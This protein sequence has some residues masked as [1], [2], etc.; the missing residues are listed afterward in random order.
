MHVAHA[1]LFNIKTNP[2]LWFRRA[3]Q[4]TWR[5]AVFFIAVRLLKRHGR[6]QKLTMYCDLILSVH[7]LVDFYARHVHIYL[8]FCNLLIHYLVFS[9]GSPRSSFCDK[10]GGSNLILVKARVPTWRIHFSVYHFLSPQGRTVQSISLRGDPQE[11][12][13]DGRR[14]RQGHRPPN[15]RLQRAQW[16]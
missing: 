9:G 5:S 2:R 11:P 12:L 14:G 16:P 6:W 4:T 10:R 15:H 3:R 7:P 13:V 8:F 1:C